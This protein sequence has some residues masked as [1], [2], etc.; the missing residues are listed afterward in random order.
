VGQAYAGGY[1]KDNIVVAVDRVIELVSKQGINGHAAALRWT[2]YHSKLQADLGDG[3]IVAASSV[4]QLESN[5]GFIEQGPLPT[6]VL[7]AIDEVYT[8][9]AG[10]EFPYHH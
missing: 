4:A 5:F 3:I 7:D 9:V 1:L 10:T 8:E 6:E 2:V